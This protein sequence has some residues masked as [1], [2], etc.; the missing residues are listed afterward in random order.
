MALL[1][2]TDCHRPVSSEAVA[3]PACGRPM[4]ER[5]YLTPGA[6]V[7]AGGV[8]LIAVLAWPPLFFILVFIF[9]GRLVGRAR[10]GSN[11]IVAAAAGLIVALAIGLTY[12]LPGLAVIVL[13]VGVGIILWLIG[14]RLRRLEAQG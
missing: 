14:P 4:R 2:C 5:S 13:I 9:I 6:Q 10:R 11:H 12:F 1:T 7:V 3:C 8:V